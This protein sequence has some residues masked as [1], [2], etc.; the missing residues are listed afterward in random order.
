MFQAGA[1]LMCACHFSEG[2]TA[3]TRPGQ[4]ARG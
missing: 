2:R 3:T 4:T 1:T